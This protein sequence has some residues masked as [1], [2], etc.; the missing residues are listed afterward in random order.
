MGHWTSPR[1]YLEN[2]K[3]FLNHGRTG[4]GPSHSTKKTSFAFSK[5]KAPL[6]P[7]LKNVILFLFGGILFLLVIYFL[8]PSKV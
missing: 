4:I 5:G 3:G 2:Q 8:F 6:R 1:S 7:I